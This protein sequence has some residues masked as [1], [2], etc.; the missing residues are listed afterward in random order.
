MCECVSGEV[1]G[2]R[3]GEVRKRNPSGWK[4]CTFSCLAPDVSDKPPQP[5]SKKYKKKK[6][7]TK[8]VCE[9]QHKLHGWDFGSAVGGWVERERGRQ[10][11]EGGGSLLCW[12]PAEV[13]F[14]GRR[15]VH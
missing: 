13:T 4:Q 15:G 6:K 14:E 2:S 9:P 12:I 7:S 10:G 11:E 1:G 8:K 5:P 3:G